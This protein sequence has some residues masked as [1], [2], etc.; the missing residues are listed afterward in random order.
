DG[1]CDSSNNI[2]SCL[3]DGGDCCPSTCVSTAGLCICD[4]VNNN[5]ECGYD[6]GDCCPS[7]CVVSSTNYCP[8][9]NSECVNP[10]ADDFGYQDFENCT[11][12]P[13]SMGNGLCIE[14]NNNAECG[15]DGGDCCE[16]S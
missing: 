6:G 16:C 9:D 1:V 11:G 14:E 2:A 10:F 7:T 12:Y 13:P 5:A 8:E 4:E 3:Y 15:Y